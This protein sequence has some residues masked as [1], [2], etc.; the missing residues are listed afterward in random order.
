MDQI[1]FSPVS[2]EMAPAKLAEWIL[3]DSLNVRLHLQLH[4]IIWPSKEKGV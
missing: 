3:E 2:G 1:L 4:K